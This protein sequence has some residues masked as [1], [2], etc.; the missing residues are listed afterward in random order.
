MRRLVLLSLLVPSTTLAATIRVGEDADAEDLAEAL[1]M[2]ASGDE[3]VLPAGE[4]G[5]VVL[6]DDRALTIRG[7]GEGGRV[8]LGS[9]AVLSPA[10]SLTVEDVTVEGAPRAVIAE[11][12]TVELHDV[13]VEN[14]GT[15]DGG[16]AAEVS[17]GGSLTWRGGRVHNVV[18]GE[19]ILRAIS[20]GSLTLESLRVEENQAGEAMLFAYDATVTIDGARFVLNRSEGWGGAISVTAAELVASDLDVRQNVAAYGGGIYVGPDATAEIQDLTMRANTAEHDGGHIFQSGGELTLVRSR[21][22]RGSADRGGAVAMADGDL[23]VRN[24]QWSGQE[25][26]VE[27]GALF[28]SGGSAAI[29][30][31]V[32][33]GNPGEIGG[34]IALEGGDAWLAGVILYGNAAEAIANAGTGSVDVSTSLLSHNLAND[35]TLGD[36]TLAEDVAQADPLFAD[37]AYEN[38]VLMTGSPAID[39]WTDGELDPD[40]T[41]ADMGMYGGPEAWPLADEDGDGFVVG[42]DCDDADPDTHEGAEDAWYDGVDSNCDGASDWDADG[43]GYDTW[44]HGGLDCVDTNPNVHPGATE[45]PWD[46][47]DS[48]CDGLDEPDE[49]GDGWSADVDCDD[50]DPTVFPGRKEDW[51]DGIDQNCD[52]RSDYDQDGDGY[53][54]AEYGGE[55]CDDRDFWV[56]PRSPEIPGDG[57]DNDCDGLTLDPAGV[58]GLDASADSG[59]T[60]T[61]APDVP[62]SESPESRGAWETRTTCSTAGGGAAS[63]AWLAALALVATRRRDEG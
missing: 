50:T 1:G 57:I 24:A 54:A 45:R 43:D 26:A 16:F 52:G 51:Y 48:D 11:G 30:F 44:R 22:T 19:G 7:D 42:R 6:T 60:S 34:G 59:T 8:F 3:I 58:G 35:A 25:A 53:D 13:N 14:G 21:L 40:G 2:A 9:I 29:S 20:G 33:A 62:D 12:G 31:A 23:V 5:P 46:A 63:L 15:P 18:G 4:H 56:N 10:A 47:W 32:L 28:M 36:V 39:A 17:A 27:G 37:P 55:D 38:Y 41:P 61:G 49:D